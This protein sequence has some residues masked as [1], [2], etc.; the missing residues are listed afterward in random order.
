MPAQNPGDPGGMSAYGRWM[1]GPWFWPPAADTVYGPIDNPY[2]DPACNLDDP[3]TWTYQTDPFCEPPQ[4]P[5]TPNLSAGMEQFND[6][7]T[8]NGVAYPEVTL[9]PK[10]YRFRILNAANDRSF[11]LQWYIADPSTGTTER[12]RP[13]PAGARCGADRPQSC[14]R[15][16]SRTRR[17]PARTGSTSAPRAASC[18]PRPWWTASS[19]PRGSPTRPASTSATWTCTRW[20]WLQPSGPTSS[21]TSR[22][23]PARR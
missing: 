6:T 7:P 10:A 13:E 2:Y 12:G 5:G 4:I 15:R 16:R 21:S 1:Y 11:N 19:R 14:S 8:V 22:R 3:A 20:R 9:Q 17:P 18:R 23:S